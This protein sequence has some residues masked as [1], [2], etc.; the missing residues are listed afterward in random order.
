M[1]AARLSRGDRSLRRTIL[2]AAAVLAISV[3]GLVAIPGST[4]DIEAQEGT[5]TLT[6]SL[7]AGFNAVAYLGPNAE[8]AVVADEI[9]DGV[10]AIF[11]LVGGAYLSYW[12]GLG[13]NA[14]LLNNLKMVNTGDAIFV[15]LADGIHLEWTQAIPSGLPFHLLLGPGF[16]FVVFTGPENTP[17]ADRFHAGGC[18][19]AIFAWDALP[20]AWLGFFPGQSLALNAVLSIDRFDVLMIFNSCDT[21]TEVWFVDEMID[22][23]Q[24]ETQE[25]A[26]A[27]SLDKTND[28]AA[29]LGGTITYTYTVSNTGNTTLTA[30]TVVD[31]P[32]GP[33]AIG[34]TAGNGVDVLEP[35]DI[36]TGA[37]THTVTPTDINNGVVVNEATAEGTA[38][39]GT[40]VSDSV[41]HTVVLQP[42]LR[43]PRP[44]RLQA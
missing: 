16:N 25:P 14:D 28:G 40:T 27:I 29:P 3:L 24:G 15:L 44:H 20:A 32:L 23:E 17:L 6:Q 8:P 7:W 30:V 5:G 12:A 42:R 10:L 26:P 4:S 38:P 36:E 18:I 2:A 33:I 41:T 13:E 21:V 19:I 11:K 31:D 37:A 34:D 43:R 1:C 9:G 39:D 22:D 35:G